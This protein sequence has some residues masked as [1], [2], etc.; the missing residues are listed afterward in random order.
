MG[1]CYILVEG[2]VIAG[3]ILSR[4]SHTCFADDWWNVLRVVSVQRLSL[5]LVKS[6]L[7]SIIIASY[8][9]AYF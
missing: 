6:R 8:A 4:S 2:T 5:D 9:Q 1:E 3:A 7:P